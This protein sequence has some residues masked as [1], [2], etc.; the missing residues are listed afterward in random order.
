M[1]RFRDYILGVL[2][3]VMVISLA[4]PAMAANY[5]KNM[6]V[7]Y[8]DI[9]I[10]VDGSYFSPKDATGR[11]VEPFIY[12][13]T[14]YLPVRGVAEAVGYNVTWDNNTSTVYLVNGGGSGGGN[15]GGTATAPAVNLIDTLPPYQMSSSCRYYPT[16]GNN[17][18]TMGGT[19]HKNSMYFYD[20][21]GGTV[22]ADF[23]LGGKY[24]LIS[25]IA[26]CIDGYSK[27][28]TVTFYGD[29]VALKTVNIVG[30][31]L[32]ANFSVDVTGVSG[33]KVSV[34]MPNLCRVGMAEL[35]IQ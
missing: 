23:N 13:G 8:R 34:T 25:G 27:N 28:A 15:N 9:K 21:S 3:V 26:G 17:A 32:P 31:E 11:T 29:G 30:G 16:S 19:Q 35:L 5:N 22:T 33:F 10:S 14:T 18:I 7:T 2:T 20:Y 12:E 1:K 4:V 6:N 24:T